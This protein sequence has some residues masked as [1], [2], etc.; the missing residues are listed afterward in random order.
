[1]NVVGLCQLGL[2]AYDQC[3]LFPSRLFKSFILL[4]L[5][6]ISKLITQSLRA[7]LNLIPTVLTLFFSFYLPIWIL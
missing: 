6:F 7:L 3:S 5:D 4:F 2:N 1:M